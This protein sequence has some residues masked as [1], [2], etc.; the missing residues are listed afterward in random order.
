MPPLPERRLSES[1]STSIWLDLMDRWGADGTAWVPISP[2]IPAG[3]VDC[4]WVEDEDASTAELRRLAQDL[5]HE[6]IFELHEGGPRDPATLP[7]GVPW[8]AEVSV[9]DWDPSY[10]GLERYSTPPSLDWLVYASHEGT[11][12][13]AGAPIVDLLGSDSPGLRPFAGARFTAFDTWPPR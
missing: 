3:P 6:T 5:G 13:V 7:R 12:T 1:E 9:K 4:Y 2:Q 10:V 11:L 8:D